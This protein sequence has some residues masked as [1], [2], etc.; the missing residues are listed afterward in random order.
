MDGVVLRRASIIHVM[1][2]RPMLR[3]TSTLCRIGELEIRLSEDICA[4]WRELIFLHDV[5]RLQADSRAP[6]QP[7]LLSSTLIS[8]DA[9]NK[10]VTS[11]A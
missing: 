5:E 8:V 3:F 7:E 1:S 9:G 2:I 6:V 11:L 4:Q 10:K